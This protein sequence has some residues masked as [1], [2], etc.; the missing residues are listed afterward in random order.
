MKIIE[1]TQD[2][3]AWY[4]NKLYQKDDKPD[5]SEFCQAL[6]DYDI[7]TDGT[8]VVTAVHHPPALYLFGLIRVGEHKSDLKEFI[9]KLVYN[10]YNPIFIMWHRGKKLRVYARD[11]AGQYFRVKIEKN[12]E[13]N[14]WQQL[15]L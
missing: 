1:K 9:R 8:Y 13:G 5:F 6:A 3:L 2:F 14:Q 4:Y 7:W 11:L 12:M 15:S 10:V